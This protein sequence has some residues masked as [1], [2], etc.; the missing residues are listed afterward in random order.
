LRV[1]NIPHR[2]V[3]CLSALLAAGVLSQARAQG[4]PDAVLA[5]ALALARQAAGAF[6]PPGARIEVQP[7][8]LDRR[9]RL[10]PCTRVEP[11]L[12]AATRVWGRT[13]VGLRCL[14]GTTAWKVFLPLT[15]KVLAPGLVGTLPLPAGTVIGAGQLQLAEVDWAAEASPVQVRAEALLGR[16]LARSIGAGQP[17]RAADVRPRQWFAA[18]DTVS[19]VASGTGFSVSGEGQA[20]SNGIEGQ[21][22]RVRTDSGRLL[23]GHPVGERRVEVAL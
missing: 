3:L 18:G 2:S 15:V 4:L 7:G 19:I 10:A 5:P 21:P 14:Q 9:L 11:F 1:V 8:T 20:V 13:R 16:T 22:A 12:P 17:V 23:N 6:A